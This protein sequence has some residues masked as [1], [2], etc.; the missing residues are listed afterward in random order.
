M[1]RMRPCLKE[2][3]YQIRWGLPIWTLTVLTT[4][5]PNN[6]ITIK[7]RGFLHRPFFKKCGR[8]LQMASGVQILNPH[9]IEIGD[10]VYLSYNVWLN[11][12]GGITIEDEVVIGPYV[13]ISSL[14]HGYKNKSFRFGGALEEP[15]R[16][17]KG[18]W[19]AAH[20][21]VAFGVSIGAGCLVTANSAVTRNLPDG[22]MAGG[23]PA[24]IIKDCEDKDPTLFSRS[25]F[26]RS[27]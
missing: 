19:L 3:F 15:V 2:I 13:T 18:S 21:S 26:T 10:N 8:N 11:G 24:E 4:W 1:N 12:L 20:V 17:G 7:I 5:W 16:V 6:R 27:A 23:V 25:G 14:S 22:K 9:K